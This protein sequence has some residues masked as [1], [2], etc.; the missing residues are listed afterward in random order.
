MARFQQGMSGNP[1]GK[2]PGT[3]NKA[4]LLVIKLMESGA[5]EITEAVIA[6]ARNGD[7]AAARMILDRLAP[8]ARERPIEIPLPDTSTAQGVADAQRAVLDAVASGE[9]MPG[10]AATLAGVIDAR[11]RAIELVEIEQRLRALEEQNK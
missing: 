11:R 6:A 4:T 2:A 7:M 8:P 9:I 1:R 3:R 10:E 5:K